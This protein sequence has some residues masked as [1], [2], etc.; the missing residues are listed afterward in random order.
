MYSLAEARK[1]RLDFR[2]AGPFAAL[3]LLQRFID[4]GQ[5]LRG[6]LVGTGAKAI[7]R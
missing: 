4:G 3:N 1:R 5:F 7:E 2:R 6:G